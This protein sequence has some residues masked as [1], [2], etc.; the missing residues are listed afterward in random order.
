LNGRNSKFK[1]LVLGFS[2][3]LNS[4]SR[5]S[6]GAWRVKVTQTQVVPLLSQTSS[7]SSC[8]ETNGHCANTLWRIILWSSLNLFEHH[9]KEYLCNLCPE[10]LNWHSQRTYAHLTLF[11]NHHHHHYH[12]TATWVR[13]NTSRQQWNNSIWNEKLWHHTSAPFRICVGPFHVS[14]QRWA[15]CKSV[16]Q[17]RRGLQVSICEGAHEYAAICWLTLIWVK[18][19]PF[20]LKENPIFSRMTP[21]YGPFSTIV[22]SCSNE[23]KVQQWNKWV[24]H[25]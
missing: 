1:I 24:S 11:N 19:V 16:C 9:Q 7:S 6:N 23:E 13:A 14:S 3:H 5:I 20:K 4:L 8:W 22:K 17:L 18:L 12:H 10:N 21:N 25:D 2:F 15:S